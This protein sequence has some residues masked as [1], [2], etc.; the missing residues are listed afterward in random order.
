KKRVKPNTQRKIRL[1]KC[2]GAE[3]V[4]WGDSARL[5]R[6]NSSSILISVMAACRRA[7]SET[8]QGK[9]FASYRVFS[10]PG[11]P[12]LALRDSL[13][14]MRWPKREDSHRL[15]HGRY[16]GLNQRRGMRTLVHKAHESA[17]RSRA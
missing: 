7:I 2:F 6:L 1:R 16:R 3:S 12:H 4:E 10:K 13:H 8:G 14:Q 5:S 17:A 15:D 11:D 9:Q